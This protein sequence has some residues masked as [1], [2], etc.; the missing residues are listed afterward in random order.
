MSNGGHENKA[1]NG[2]EELHDVI[3]NDVTSIICEYTLMQYCLRQGLGNVEN[4][5]GKQ[6]KSIGAD[7]QY[8]C[9]SDIRSKTADRRGKK[10]A[11]ASLIFLTE[12]KMEP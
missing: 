12:K 8:R 5:Q 10:G 2:K 7:T 11:I 3:G 9:T 1:P 4:W 6:Q